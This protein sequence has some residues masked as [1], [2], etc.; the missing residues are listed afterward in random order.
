MQFVEPHPM[1]ALYRDI[2]G[3][4]T[5]EFAADDGVLSEPWHEAPNRCKTLVVAPA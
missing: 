4:D 1:R 2:I 3:I 5:F